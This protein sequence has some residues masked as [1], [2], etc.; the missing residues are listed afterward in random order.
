MQRSEQLR[1]IDVWTS[2]DSSVCVWFVDSSF[3]AEQILFVGTCKVISG[4]VTSIENFTNALIAR[5]IFGIVCISV[6][7]DGRS[8]DWG[9]LAD[10]RTRSDPLAALSAHAKACKS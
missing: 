7:L 9:S 6:A 5:N 1:A 2:F 3:F 10:I 4:E 8:A